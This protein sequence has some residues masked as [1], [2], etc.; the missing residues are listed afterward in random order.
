MEQSRA[1]R[2]FPQLAIADL[3][4]AQRR[5]I[6]PVLAFAG[7]IS[8]PFNATLR[9]AELTEKSFAL[10]EHLLFG[11]TLPRRLVEM[12]VLIRARFSFS[13]LEWVAHERRALEETLSP[14]ICAALREGRRPEAMA[15]DEAALYDFSIEM[16][17]APSVSDATFARAKAR[18]GERGVVELAYLIGFYGMISLV[19]KVAE[20]GA[21][22]GSTPLSPMA[23]PFPLSGMAAASP[24]G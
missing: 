12:A 2:R 19:L 9:S 13:Q 18:F 23:D 24:P 8:G 3:D 22:G 5:A 20:V 14:Q 17:K 7:G 21:P 10:G 11:T 6:E 16:L 4:Q 1:A 15:D